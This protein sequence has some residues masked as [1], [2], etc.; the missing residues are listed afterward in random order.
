[1]SVAP[2]RRCEVSE[3]IRYDYDLGLWL[4]QDVGTSDLVTREV[5]RHLRDIIEEQLSMEA[6]DTII[7]LD[8]A[9]IERMDYTGVDECFAKLV[10]RLQAMEYGDLYVIFSGVVAPDSLEAAMSRKHLACLVNGPDGLQGV[11]YLHRYLCPVFRRLQTY[12]KLTA[13]DLAD[14]TNQEIN[15]ASSDLLM[16]WKFRLARRVSQRL[17]DGGRQ[18][19]YYAIKGE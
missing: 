18:Y 1:M 17:P 19:I 7:T 6:A 12:S 8:C 2:R 11:G 3:L 4:K 9:G 5:G 15:R 10:V 14:D 13:R 16:L